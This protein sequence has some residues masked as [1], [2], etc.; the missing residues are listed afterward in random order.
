MRKIT[1]IL[2]LPHE[3]GLSYRAIAQSLNIGYG[4]VV[5]YFTRAETA[6]IKWPLP[7]GMKERDLGALLF[8]AQ[9]VTGQR[10][11]VEP[12]F[13]AIQLELKRKGVT[14]L[15]LWEEHRQ[16]YLDDGYSYP[17]FC[18]RYAAWLGGQQRSMRQVHRAGEKLFVD[19]CGPTM[20][21]VNPDTGE[22]RKD[23]MPVRYASNL[24]RQVWRR[25]EQQLLQTAV[26]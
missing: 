8:P 1:D 25:R 10:R 22:I 21:V 11:F 24:S 2:R 7:D 5:D 14:K 16:H 20:P 19:Y 9:P 15:L 17:Q 4:T 6:E 23:L 12:D 26:A 3:A 18:A 13:S